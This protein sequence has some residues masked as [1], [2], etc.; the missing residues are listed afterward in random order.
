MP[1]SEYTSLLEKLGFK[2]FERA[3]LSTT[4]TYS[5]HRREDIEEMPT[6]AEL[7]VPTEFGPIFVMFE[8]LFPV[9]MVLDELNQSWYVNKII[10][11]TTYGFVNGMEA[12][13]TGVLQ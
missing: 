6:R 12:L 4:A 3:R 10:D 7:P 5:I 13:T 1:E 11:M 8:G 9:T 2:K